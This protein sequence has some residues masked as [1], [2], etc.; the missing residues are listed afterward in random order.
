MLQGWYNACAF[1]IQNWILRELPFYMRRILDESMAGNFL[2]TRKDPAMSSNKWSESYRVTPCHACYDDCWSRRS[3]CWSW[4]TCC[5][6]SG[7]SE[8]NCSGVRFSTC[9][10]NA[11][12]TSGGSCKWARQN[13]FSF[14][15]SGTTKAFSF[16]VNLIN[17]HCKKHKKTASKIT[18]IPPDWEA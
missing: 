7:G 15:I 3:A 12:S 13:T 14:C 5:R 4:T 17:I 18:I 10:S 11:D 6:C 1:H 16:W 8:F 2:P 9:W